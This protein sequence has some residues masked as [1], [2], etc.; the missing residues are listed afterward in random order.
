MTRSLKLHALILGPHTRS[1][2]QAA[3]T[4]TDPSAITQASVV[5]ANLESAPRW[6]VGRGRS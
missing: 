6:L 5:V 3:V 1:V 2:T 4:V